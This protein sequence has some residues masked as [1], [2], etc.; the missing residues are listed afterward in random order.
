MKV[1]LNGLASSFFF[2]WLVAFTAL[3]QNVPS[4]RFKM[5]F[6]SRE[7]LCESQLSS[8]NVR[9]P[10]DTIPVCAVGVDLPANARLPDW[11]DVD[12]DANL[13][14]VHR[15]E[16][17]LRYEIKP[18]PEF[19]FETWRQQFAKRRSVASS[20]PHLKRF[21][22]RIYGT[23]TPEF[24]YGY[25]IGPGNCDPQKV[26]TWANFPG[27]HFFMY[28]ADKDIADRL[29]LLPGHLALFDGQ[30]Y[31]LSSGLTDK[32]HFWVWRVAID[33]IAALPQS[34]QRAN[35]Y[36]RP[37]QRNFERQTICGIEASDMFPP[38]PK[39]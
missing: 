3:G 18:Q 17:E 31:A 24:I 19:E 10:D 22:L 11:Q 16:W 29:P 21:P 33:K 7:P 37:F 38:P 15:I 5:M 9:A 28:D 13:R 2:A 8:L 30:A 20:R 34:L 1:K 27:M 4:T 25:S 26:E 35:T 23:G 39:K 14:L 32:T 36:Y 12:L 6:E